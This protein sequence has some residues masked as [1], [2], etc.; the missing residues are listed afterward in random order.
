MM[1]SD[2]IALLSR[3]LS[4]NF[5]AQILLTIAALIAGA[6]THKLA[7]GIESPVA[8]TVVSLFVLLFWG[9]LWEI[10]ETFWA[11]IFTVCLAVV[12]HEAYQR[13]LGAYR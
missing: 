3:L 13:L 7:T 10:G 4:M 2:F 12:G 11:I 1:L 5:E 6:L 8:L 9:H